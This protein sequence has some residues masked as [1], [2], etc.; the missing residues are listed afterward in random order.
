MRVDE[1]E[2]WER[3]WREISPEASLFGRV[4]SLV[5]TQLLSRAVRNYAERFFPD[6]GVVVEAG[7]GTAQSSG[8]LPRGGRTAVA[9]DFSAAALRAARSVSV[10]AGSVQGDVERLPFASGSVSGIWNLGVMEHFEAARGIRI[11]REF[12]RVLRPGACA[13]LFWP[14]EFGSS[15]LVLGPIEAIRSRLSRRDFRFFPDEVNRLRSRDHARALLGEAG[16]DAVTL[17]FSIR[18]AF[19]HLVV[20]ARRPVG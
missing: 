7:C 3:H 16:L 15:R 6:E 9:L 17:D 5:R 2:T 4:A 1:R 13:V 8:R 11:L 20:V 10:F 12:R 14:P 19:I 18:D